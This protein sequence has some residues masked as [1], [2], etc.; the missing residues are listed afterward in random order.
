LLYKEEKVK[1]FEIQD[2][3]AIKNAEIKIERKI[4]QIRIDQ[5]LEV[6]KFIKFIKL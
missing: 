6:L 4:T 3:N 5:E 1:Y 2:W